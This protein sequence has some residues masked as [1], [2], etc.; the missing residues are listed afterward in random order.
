M[1]AS[2][3]HLLKIAKRAEKLG[4]TST[5]FDAY[6]EVLSNFSSNKAAL[7]RRFDL[8][9]LRKREPAIKSRE[10]REYEEINKKLELGV[11]DLTKLNLK[12]FIFDNPSATFAY[13]EYSKLCAKEEISRFVT[14]L[15]CLLENTQKPHHKY[16][17]LYA[18]YICAKREG[19]FGNA[20]KYIKKANEIKRRYG[21]YDPERD[22]QDI[23][24]IKKKF[25]E[26][27][28]TS[29]LSSEQCTHNFIFIIGM[30]RSGTTLVEQI[31]SNA[32][33]VVSVGEAPFAGQFMSQ[34]NLS[35]DLKEISKD[36]SSFYTAKI[37]K[38]KFSEN[39]I[40]DKMPFN[41]F[42][43]G[44]LAFSF[45]NAEF[46]HCKRDARATCWSNYETNF[47]GN[48]MFYSFKLEEVVRHYN[49][50]EDLII[51]WKSKF[52][53]RIFTL[54]YDALTEEP[55]IIGRNLFDFL[56]LPWSKQYLNT[57]QDNRPVSTASRL[58]VKK[59]IYRGSSQVWKNFEPFIGEAFEP[60]ID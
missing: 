7:K 38:Y 56:Q 22:E 46:V 44:F 60:L 11:S 10:S 51:F 19:N 32:E 25:V 41:L 18:L 43:L 49:N 39:H 52:Q 15:S 13:S 58:Q 55:E 29:T 28:D 12:K 27:G 26:F 16:N 47:T 53:D 24:L 42:W 36:L 1:P 33:G 21:K 40:I 17:L 57:K 2:A 50:C 54:D 59:V 45:P 30:P 23:R 14:T 9:L 48:D 4:D 37:E 5:A 3:A 35:R 8:D 31:I 20:F 6:S 34:T